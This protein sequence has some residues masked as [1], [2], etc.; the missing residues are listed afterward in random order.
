MGLKEFWNGVKQKAP[1]IIG[2]G[3]MGGIAAAAPAVD[4]ILAPYTAGVPVV[5]TI[6]NA[7]LGYLQRNAREN[8][9]NRQNRKNELYTQAH[10]QS[11]TGEQAKAFVKQQLGKKGFWSKAFKGAAQGQMIKLPSA[12]NDTSNGHAPIGYSISPSS[13][14]PS[15]NSGFSSRPRRKKLG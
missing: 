1:G 10:A 15:L 6:A 13:N 5:S 12:Q 7:G 11:L 4:S 2:R 8:A 3:I 9:Y 14:K